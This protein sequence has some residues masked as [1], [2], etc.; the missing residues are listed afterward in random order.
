MAHTPLLIGADGQGLSKRLGSLSMGE[1]RAQGYEPM[2][3]CSL[4]AKIGTS[5]NVE[6][7]ETLDQLAAEFD[8]AKI[9]RSPAR[10]DEAELKSLIETVR[11]R[12]V[13]QPLL[14][15]RTAE[16]YEIVAGERRWRAAQAAGLTEIPVYVT[17]ADDEQSFELSMIEN[18]QRQNLDPIEEAAGYA[19]LVE[20]AGFSHDEIATRVGKDRT[21]ISNALRLLKLAAEVQAMLVEGRLSPGHGRALLGLPTEA[22]QRRMAREVVEQS[23]SVRELE[24][25]VQAS[26]SG[27][28]KPAGV[29]KAGRRLAPDLEA[30]ERRL[31]RALMAK[32]RIQPS[33]RGTSGK[34]EVRYASLAEFERI[35]ERMLGL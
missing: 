8:F 12:G 1:L 11:E 24:R 13:L 28:G 33:A 34:I 17:D 19:K 23:L 29:P 5:D 6:P 3:V 9:G 31:E 16:G 26:R 4:L 15:R 27:A 7:R 25:R 18:L 10:F 14:V 20:L 21:T 35:R 32:V 22:E 2:S 30:V